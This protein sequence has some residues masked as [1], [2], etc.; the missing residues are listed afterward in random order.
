MAPKFDDI[1]YSKPKAQ[2]SPSIRSTSSSQFSG[3]TGS[4]AGIPDGLQ[5][6]L[7]M[8][9]RTCPPCSVR[10]FNV[11]EPFHK[12]INWCRNI[13]TAWSTRVKISHSIFGSKVSR[14]PEFGL[15][16]RLQKALPRNA[17]ISSRIVS[18]T[19]L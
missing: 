2:R 10:D 11:T 4:S 13:S 19:R 1:W 15:T 3:R 14:Q 6:Q 5:L 18:Q 8:D 9:G 16:C 17:R 12:N 7:I